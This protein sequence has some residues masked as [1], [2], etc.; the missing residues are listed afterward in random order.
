MA[1]CALEPMDLNPAS[2][3]VQ[4]KIIEQLE[5]EILV[6]G[7]RWFSLVVDG[8]IYPHLRHVAAERKTFR[9]RNDA[10]HE[11][12]NMLKSFNELTFPIFTGAFAQTQ[13]YT[14]PKQLL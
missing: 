10:L 4:L 3:D 12:M 7:R 8:G 14:T 5:G 6:D 9:L 2:H 11:E 1:F 13:G